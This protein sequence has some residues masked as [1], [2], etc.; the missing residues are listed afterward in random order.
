MSTVVIEI[1]FS[2]STVRINCVWCLHTYCILALVTMLF[3]LS[4]FRLVHD[5][6]LSLFDGSQLL[7]KDKYEAI[8]T[9]QGL[10]DA[11]MTH[12]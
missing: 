6:E 1:K 12:R 11:E 9:E 2:V 3:T 7:R 10:S 4:T 5:R 8:K